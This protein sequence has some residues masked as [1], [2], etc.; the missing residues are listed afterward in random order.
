M[1]LQRT[2]RVWGEKFPVMSME[3]IVKVI[4]EQARFILDQGPQDQDVFTKLGYFAFQPDLG[5]DEGHLG[6]FE[7]LSRIIGQIIEQIAGKNIAD[8]IGKRKLGSRS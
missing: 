5:F 3:L 2:V 6:L 7:E 8:S 1:D 4:F